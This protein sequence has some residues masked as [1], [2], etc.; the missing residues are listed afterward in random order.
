MR[1]LMDCILYNILLL[2]IFTLKFM[3]RAEIYIEWTDFEHCQVDILIFGFST[4]L[5]ID[6]VPLTR[7]KLNPIDGVKMTNS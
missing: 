2:L 4:E 6:S 5:I 3:V 1:N 7:P